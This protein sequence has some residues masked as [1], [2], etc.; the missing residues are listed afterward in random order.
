MKIYNQTEKNEH[1]G[2]ENIKNRFA[3]ESKKLQH[4][5]R[6]DSSVANFIVNFHSG[7]Y[8]S[9]SRESLRSAFKIMTGIFE[10]IEIIICRIS[11]ECIENKEQYEHCNNN[12]DCHRKIYSSFAFGT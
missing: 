3:A 7:N 2:I 1:K 5:M 12:D 9:Y 10:K 8:I 4:K 11:A 6:R